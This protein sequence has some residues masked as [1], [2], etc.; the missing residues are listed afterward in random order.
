MIGANTRTRRAF[1]PRTA[2]LVLAASATAL[3]VFAGSGSAASQAAPSL[4][5]APFITGTEQEGKELTAD[6]GSWTGDPTDYDYQWQRCNSSG[7]GCSDISGADNQKYTL[8][9]ADLGNRVRVGVTA[10]NADGS[11]GPVYSAA[12]GEIA[13]AGAAPANSA[14]PSISGTPQ[15]NQTLTA[16]NG[17]W[18][19]S[20][21]ITYSYSWQRCDSA[22]NNCSAIGQS[23][24]AYR[25]SSNDVGHRLRVVVTATNSFGSASATSAPTGVATAAGTAPANAA[26]PT[27]TGT[28]QDNLT[29]TAIGGT[30]NG[31]AP[32]ALSYQWLRCD[33]N[34]NACAPIPGATGST[35]KGTSAD[36]GH[37]LRVAVTGKNALGSSTA[38]SAP[39]GVVAAA[40]PAGAIKLADGA[41]SIP[42]TS[43]SLPDRLVI[44]RVAFDPPVIPSRTRP[45]TAR[46]RIVDSKG[47]VVRDALV[48]AIG[49]PSNRVTVPPETKTDQSGWATVVYQPLRGLPLKRGARLTIFVRA[50]KPGES[51]LGGVSTRRLVSIGVRPL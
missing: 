28:P 36:V 24:Q 37:R 15:D 51:V 14:L 13:A 18:S 42:I 27:I 23:S 38:T 12:T 34:G 26:A 32:V 19:G 29:L 30:W 5:A 44:S 11:T 47:Y 3:L 41:T 33:A 39:T 31:T 40:G 2:V 10:T 9:S 8:G 48:Y 50:R 49:V 20:S 4:Q 16:S 35:Y 45:I 1:G 6:H 46:F 43:V 17:T 22:G 21:P 7:S 25:V